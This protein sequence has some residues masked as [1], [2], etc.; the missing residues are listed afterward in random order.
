MWIAYVVRWRLMPSTVFGL[1]PVGESIRLGLSRVYLPWAAF[2]FLFLLVK[3]YSPGARLTEG[4]R[5]IS[6]DHDHASSS[7]S[8][9]TRQARAQP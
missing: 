9:R 7:S 5:Q 4:L 3:P 1:L 8:S 2:Y 6:H